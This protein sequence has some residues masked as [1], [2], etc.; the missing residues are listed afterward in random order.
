LPKLT[1]FYLNSGLAGLSSSGF[2]YI[3]RQ[4]CIIGY[5]KWLISPLTR[6]IMLPGLEISVLQKLS[7]KP[8]SW[9]LFEDIQG[10]GL[11]VNYNDANEPEI[12]QLILTSKSEK[13]QYKT[14]DCAMT[15]I[16]S[17]Q[18]NGVI[19]FHFLSAGQ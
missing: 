8:T 9:L 11:S 4:F 15:D 19:H 18:K 12:W 16:R 13:K 10:F 17:V 7:K 6:S 3:A 5:Q 14:A 2:F 1:A